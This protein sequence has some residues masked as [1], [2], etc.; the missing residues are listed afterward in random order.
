MNDLL[1]NLKEYHGF[2]KGQLYYNF[3]YNKVQMIISDVESTPETKK[4]IADDEWCGNLYSQAKK[5]EYYFSNSTS[6]KKKEEN[7]KAIISELVVLVSQLH[8]KLLERN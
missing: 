5:N 1:S 7:F 8:S 4:I 6:K 2:L 3:D